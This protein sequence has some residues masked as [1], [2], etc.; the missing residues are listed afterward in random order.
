[1]TGKHGSRL[2]SG[3]SCVA[4]GAPASCFFLLLLPAPQ[5]TCITTSKLPSILDVYVI[6]AQNVNSLR[7]W[8]L[9]VRLKS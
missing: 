3:E 8:A 6:A 9:I 7:L 1:M 5:I 2:L 4:S